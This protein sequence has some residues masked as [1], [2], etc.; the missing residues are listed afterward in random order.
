MGSKE[1]TEFS[2]GHVELEML[3]DLHVAMPIMQLEIG[4]Q[5]SGFGC[6]R[7]EQDNRLTDI[8]GDVPKDG[9]ARKIYDTNSENGNIKGDCEG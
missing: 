1:V 7:S 9:M 2:F 6:S 5:S 4:D 3:G 8:G